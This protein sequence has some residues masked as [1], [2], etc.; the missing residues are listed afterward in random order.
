MGSVW[1]R[2]LLPVVAERK[3]PNS[4]RKKLPQK[5]LA[6][7]EDSAK[8][9]IVQI[10]ALAVQFLEGPLRRVFSFLG[11]WISFRQS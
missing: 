1:T 3:L 9:G 8:V 6:F 11:H 2:K 10:T 4:G 7:F 5:A